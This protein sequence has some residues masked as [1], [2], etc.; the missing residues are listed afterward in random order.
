MKSNPLL[1]NGGA[2]CTLSVDKNTNF[3]V[4]P[5]CSIAYTSNTGGQNVWRERGRVVS[6]PA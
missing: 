3:V 1:V 5:E 6:E 4:A 2:I